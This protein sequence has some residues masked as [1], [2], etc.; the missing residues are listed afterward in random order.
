MTTHDTTEE[1][2]K[3]HFGSRA[4][5]AKQMSSTQEGRLVFADFYDGVSK[6]L[7]KGRLQ[8]REALRVQINQWAKTEPPIEFREKVLS[9]LSTLE[10]EQ[11]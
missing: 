10:K 5:F 3:D 8:E 1:L 4:D 11:R 2:M 7:E 9:L 6:L